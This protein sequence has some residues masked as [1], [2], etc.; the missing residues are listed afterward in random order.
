[1]PLTLCSEIPGISA[2]PWSDSA[3]LALGLPPQTHWDELPA[4]I[5]VCG[6]CSSVLDVAH[7]LAESGKLHLWES[8]IT[9]NQSAGRGQLRRPWIS[10]PG[11][12]LA[13]WRVPIPPAPWNGL[14]PLLLGWSICLTLRDMG[15]PLLL[16]W[17]ND[18]LLHGRK[19][20]GMLIEE[21]GPVLLAGI[22][23]NLAS[24]PPDDQLRA[25]YACPAGTLDELNPRLSIFELWLRL[26]HSGR[27]RYSTTLSSSTPWEFCRSM[28]NVLAY[29]GHKIRI[30]D[31]RSSVRGTCVGLHADG[32]LD[33][34]VEGEIR[35]IHSGSLTPDE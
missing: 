19:V 29:L 28:E 9:P 32:G 4:H 22:G 7:H 1:M 21:R 13:A 16:K 2:S 17:P 23:I 26:V 18:L 20:G 25:A 14:T 8:V 3:S 35:T 10:Q 12:L 5:Q 24:A 27:L 31:N 30:T 33:L 11:N 34:M 6:P 15:L